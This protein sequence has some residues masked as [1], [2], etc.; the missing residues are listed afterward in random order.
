MRLREWVAALLLVCAVTPLAIAQ[1]GMGP[2]AI[3][4][5]IPRLADIMGA[6]QLRH[7]KLMFAGNSSN[8]ELAAFELRQLNDSVA[9]AATL[10]PGIP[11]TNVT[12]MSAP[13][14]AVADAIGA[15]DKKRFAKSYGELTDGCNGCHRS[16]DRGY[17]VMQVP[18][19]SPFSDQLFPPQA[20]P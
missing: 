2:V 1:V 3:E 16:M 5:S 4:Q 6:A 14:K 17:I 20:K 13:I 8:W 12:T 19:A 18:T 9:Q 7:M 10:Y 11:V 15:K